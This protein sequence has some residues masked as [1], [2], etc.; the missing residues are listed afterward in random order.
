[1]GG[2]PDGAKRAPDPA[3]AHMAR[4][5]RQRRRKGPKGPTTRGLELNVWPKAERISRGSHL[6]DTEKWQLALRYALLPI[7][8][9]GRDRGKKLG[10]RKLEVSWGMAP[11]YIANH[12]NIPKLL[13]ARPEEKPAERKE[14]FDKGVPRVWTP[15]VR[16]AMA[17]QAEEFK[18][19]FTFQEM[20][21]T[22][23]EA[24][25]R[26]SDS[27]IWR[28]VTAEGWNTRARTRTVPLLTDKHR[29]AR[30]DWATEHVNNGWVAW[31]DVDEKWF[32][33]IALHR[34]HKVPKGQAAPLTPVQH[35]NHVPKVMFLTAIGRSRCYGRQ[36]CTS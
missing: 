9:E 6:T 35:K 29:A 24:G 19:D 2:S 14:R 32:Y 1:M 12:L 30:V 13:G 27:T 21:Q 3:Y 22:L 18:L 25:I 16:D 23:K 15:E 20:E 11:K 17:A 4:S 28:Q 26:V 7:C 33:A 5:G 34:T 10:V 8:M 36:S 31:V